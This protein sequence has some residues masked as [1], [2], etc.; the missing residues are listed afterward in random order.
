MILRRHLI[1]GAAGLAAAPLAAPA[2]RAQTRWPTAPVRF[3]VPF[4]AGGPTDVPARLIADELSKMLP[5]RVIVEN[6]TGAGVVVGSDVVAKAP[7]DGQTLL[8]T[9]IAHAA[10]R[11]IFPNLP[12]DPI[13][14]FTPV[15]LTGVIPML[16][17]VNKDLPVNSLPELI[18]LFKKNPGKYDY[19]STGNGA[20]LHLASELFLKQAGGLKVNHV[21]YRGSAAAMPDLLNG[22]VVMMLDV[23]NSAL[24][25]VTRGEVKGLAIS[26]M[27]RLPQVPNIPTFNEAGVPGYEAYTWHMV[28]APSGTPEPIVNAVNEAVNKVMAMESVK[29]RLSAL[30]M[31]TRSNTTPAT[32]KKWLGDEIVKWEAIIR[33]AGIAAN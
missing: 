15:A 17:M 12:F 18:E 16:M 14:D 6:R 1:A 22:T 13:A 29:E 31:E 10:L 23:A 5:Q 11:P 4:A 7:K 19:A 24:P 30:T 32:T 25:F 28:L 8:Y 2:V 20:A 9:T 21:P 27:N 3:V 33:E 26:G